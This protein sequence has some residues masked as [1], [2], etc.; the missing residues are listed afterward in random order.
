MIWVIAGTQDG[1]E[2]AA[3]L[4]RYSGEKVIATVISQYG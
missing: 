3:E 1:R 4:K 2:L